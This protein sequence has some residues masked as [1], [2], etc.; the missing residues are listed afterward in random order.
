[1]S[2]WRSSE[3][4]IIST[5]QFSHS[6]M[7]DTLQPQTAAHQA[8]LPITNSQSLPKLMSIDSVMSSN[9]LIL[10]HPLLLSSIFPRIRV[11]PNESV[12]CIRWPKYWSFSFSISP[13]LNIQGW[14]P[15]RD[16]QESSPAPQFENINSSV[17]SLP[18]GSTLT[19]VPDWKII[20]LTIWTFE[21]GKWPSSDLEAVRGF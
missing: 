14:F 11:F 17:L 20:T 3:P 16:S 18:Y 2:Q 6:V 12:L 10:C 1:M 13:S 19:S 7:S 15:S 21:Y 5:V 9:Q 8:S 4:C